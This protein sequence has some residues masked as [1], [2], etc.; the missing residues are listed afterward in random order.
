MSFLCHGNVIFIFD[1]FKKCLFECFTQRK[2]ME[3]RI[4]FSKELF[5]CRQSDRKTHKINPF[6]VA[7]C[8]T[9]R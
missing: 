4:A 8:T 5:L 3:L 6:L 7:Q 1:F 9:L 2:S